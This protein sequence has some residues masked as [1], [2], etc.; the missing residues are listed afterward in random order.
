MRAN[1]LAVAFLAVLALILGGCSTQKLKDE[2][3]VLDLAAPVAVDVQSFN[4]DVFIEAGSDFEVATVQVVRRAKHGYMRYEEAE[5]SLEQI[6][7][8][9]GLAPG[10]LGQILQVRTATEA[11]EPHFQEADVYITLPE[12]D[13]VFVRTTNGRVEVRGVE[14]RIDVATTNSDIRILSNRPLRRPVTAVNRNGDIL[15]RVRAE[16]T[17]EFDC[18][19]VNG[20]VVT[21]VEYGD[22][23]VAPTNDQDTVRANLNNGSNRI[24]LRTVDGDIVVSV[25]ENPE[26]VGWLVRE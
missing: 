15:Y 24:V 4:G 9:V 2:P 20:Q 18:E 10:E 16:S 19:T 11:L 21:H 7:Y 12:V 25:V 6:S 8:T 26:E 3:I 5:A 14:G 13:G 23:L 1:P 22:F 17:G